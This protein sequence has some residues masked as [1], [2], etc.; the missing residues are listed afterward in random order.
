MRLTIPLDTQH[1]QESAA[2]AD[3]MQRV[4]DVDPDATITHVGGNRI[5]VD[6]QTGL[7][8]LDSGGERAVPREPVRGADA[9]AQRVDTPP[10]PSST[11]SDTPP[12]STTK[13]A[14]AKR[15]AAS[16]R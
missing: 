14:P 3:L 11:S 2:F 7:A 13:K 12:K 6:E 5:D 1:G 4:R 8:V 15:V 16:K 9:D 10:E